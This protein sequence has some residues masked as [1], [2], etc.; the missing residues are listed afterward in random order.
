M[1]ALPEH[2][3]K[4]GKIINIDDVVAYPSHNSLAIGKVVKLNNK[5]VKVTKIIA[6]K[7]KDS[8]TNKYPYDVVKLNPEDVTFYLL[9]GKER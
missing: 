1:K 5:M 2:K 3:D 6:G 9:M 8:G 4:L 7:R